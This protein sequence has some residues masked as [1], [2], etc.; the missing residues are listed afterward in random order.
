METNFNKWL[1]KDLQEYLLQYNIDKTD[2]KGTGKNNNVIK[3]DLVRTANKITY[4]KINKI[5]S[6]NIE[7]SKSIELPD[8]IYYTII[9]N[10]QPKDII[11]LY[12]VN[13]SY[14]RVLNKPFMLKELSKQYHANI[15]TFNDF[16]SIIN[17]K[18]SC[19]KTFTTLIKNNQLYVWGDNR[20]RQL[21]LNHTNNVNVPTKLNLKANKIVCGAY[22]AIAMM[23]N[24]NL[25]V[26][27]DNRYRQLGLR[28]N[29]SKKPTKLNLNF[30]IN[31]IVSGSS[32]DYTIAITDNGLYVWGLNF[33][34]QLGLGHNNNINKPTKLNI[35]FKVN[36]IVCGG[37]HTIAMTDDGLYVWGSNDFG[38][39]GLG[40]YIDINVP[41]KLNFDFKVNKIICGGHH[42]I[43]MTDDGL[44]VWGYNY[45][46]QLGLD[47]YNNINIPT[48]LNIKANKIICG[49]FH[50]IA[51]TDN[52]L[53]VWG[54]N[55]FGQLGL[56]HYNIFINVPTK[57]IL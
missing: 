51:M 6:P 2:I 22:H 10:S 50:T 7:L 28:G 57:L 15:T 38:Q 17:I 41:T 55:D 9:K 30:K 48:K 31:K 18:I 49:G 14:Q 35:D 43:T 12:F 52:G 8:D 46:G 45:Y 1:V 19:G 39:L 34:G 26:W 37:A 33:Y 42:T 23:D 29:K 27:G 44:Y 20:F 40:H 4:K 13:Q 5:Y 36:K 53:Y 3:A 54:Y 32:S 56:G 25:Y 16:I 21:G 11:S 47:H 24:N